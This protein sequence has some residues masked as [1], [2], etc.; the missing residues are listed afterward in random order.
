MAKKVG[1]MMFHE[2]FQEGNKTETGMFLA[3]HP[4]VI[5]PASN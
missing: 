5:Q 1:E 4:T 3:I 2:K